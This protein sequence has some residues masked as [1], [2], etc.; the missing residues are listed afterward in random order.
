MSSTFCSTSRT[1]RQVSQRAEVRVDEV[2]IDVE[3]RTA[4]EVRARVVILA[5]ILRRLALEDATQDGEGDPHAEAFDEREWLR[6]QGLTS[7]LTAREAA[8]LDSPLGSITLNAILDFSWQGEALA[9]LAWAVGVRDMPPIDAI[10]DLGP[11]MDLVP[12]PWDTIKAWMSDSAIVS[13]PDA[14]WERERAEIWHWRAT[15]EL[16]R[17]EASPAER[18]DY[19]A[20]IAEVAA[21]A[22][23]AGIVAALHECDFQLR[24]RSIR[25]ISNTELDELTDITGQRLRALNWLCGFGTS[26]DVVPLD[27]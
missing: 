5:S 7:Q 26:W 13:E 10:S 4:E 19:E 9:A 1:A 15:T 23:A 21:E 27:V 8:F 11:I 6:D 24:G 3:V 22:H 18:S 14:V 12:G 20:A 16:L 17:R 25:E 2:E